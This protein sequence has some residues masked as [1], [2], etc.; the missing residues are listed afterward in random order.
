MIILKTNLEGGCEC[1]HEFFF[2][3]S[4]N[5]IANWLPNSKS[6]KLITLHV[7]PIDWGIFVWPLWNM[8]CLHAWGWEG[9]GP[10]MVLKLSLL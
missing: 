10:R 4:I 3:K 8:N 1:Y 7:N 6:D 5:W 2:K 9:M